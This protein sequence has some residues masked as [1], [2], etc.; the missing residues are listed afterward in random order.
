MWVGFL[1]GPEVGG[2]GPVVGAGVGVPAS[3]PQLEPAFP[4]LGATVGW[5]VGRWDDGGGDWLALG[6]AEDC[7]VG[8]KLGP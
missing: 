3:S 2:V 4:E 5:E 6:L 8:S 7:D 1:V